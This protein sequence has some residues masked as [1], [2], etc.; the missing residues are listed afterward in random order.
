[1]KALLYPA[2]D[3][4]EVTELP[5]P[6][7]G[8]GEARLRVAACGLCGSELETFK[9]QSPRRKP[10]LVMGHEFCGT[11]DAV[12]ADVETSWVGRRVVSNSVV[13]CRACVRCKRGDTHLCGKRQIFGMHRAGAFAHFA[14]VPIHCL[15]DWPESLSAEAACLAEPLANGIHIVN[16]VRHRAPKTALVIGAGPIGLMCQQTLQA[17]L[18]AEVCTTD[19]NADRL[20]VSQKLGA[21]Q[22]I[23]GRDDVLAQVTA[24]TD[25][26]GVD[27]V[28]DAVGAAA[29][30]R[31]SLAALRPGGTAVWIGLH[32]DAIALDSYQITLPER[33][34]L[35]TYAATL[36]ELEQALDLMSRGVVDVTSW[37]QTFTLDESVGAF[38]R[39][40]AARGAD[41]KAVFVP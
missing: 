7:P 29:T 3:H 30:K 9:N 22:V 18:G 23:N 39:M 36:Q 5:T 28:I 2:Y 15:I 8:P 11:V 6:L 14:V 35:G 1:M 16:L 37:V 17:M 13:P 40:L 32:D 27:L 31:L 41:L 19:L 4:L 21:V 10:P 20:A 12:G 33:Q 24:R 25:G 38:N 26:E 34:V